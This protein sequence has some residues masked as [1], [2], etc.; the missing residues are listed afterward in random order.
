MEN[1]EDTIFRTYM[2]KLTKFGW[3]MEFAKIWTFCVVIVSIFLYWHYKK[4]GK[5]KGKI[6]K[7]DKT[8]YEDD[9]R[10]SFLSP[11]KNRS[12]SDDTTSFLFE[13][14]TLNK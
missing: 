14:V 2:P 12:L 6:Q 8:N 1:K 11:Y 3:W 13:S 4:E 9:K 5:P 10:S 7:E